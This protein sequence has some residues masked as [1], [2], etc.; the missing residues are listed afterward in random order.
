MPIKS[1]DA[2]VEFQKQVLL[3]AQTDRDRQRQTDRDRKIA[4]C[5]GEMFVCIMKKC[6]F[7]L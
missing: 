3:V 1:R 4:L 2:I 7:V 5:Y 6:L